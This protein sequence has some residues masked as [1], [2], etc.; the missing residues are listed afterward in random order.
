MIDDRQAS[1]VQ[2]AAH[3]ELERAARHAESMPAVTLAG[4]LQAVDK[5][6]NLALPDPVRGDLYFRASSLQINAS[7]RLGKPEGL[8]LGLSWAEEAA[9]A[10]AQSRHLQAQA[11]YNV[12]NARAALAAIGT[13]NDAGKRQVALWAERR[14]FLEARRLFSTVGHDG[15]VDGRTRAMALCN[16]AN[17]LDDAGRWVEAYDTY[18]EAIRLDPTNGNALGNAAELLRR[19]IYSGRGHSGHLAAVYNELVKAAQLR[20]TEAEAIAGKETAQRWASMKLIPTE[21]HLLHSGTGG[22]YERWVTRHRLALSEVVEGLGSD[23]PRWDSATVNRVHVR[24]GEPDPPRIFGGFA[25]IKA[26]FL[27]ARKLAY[28]GGRLLLESLYSQHPSDTGTYPELGDGSLFGQT[29][30][31]LVLAQRCTLDVLDKIAVAA[32]DHFGC[33]VPPSKVTFSNFWRDGKTGAIRQGLPAPAD[34]MSAVHALAE[35]AIDLE[36]LG[37]E[38]PGIYAVGKTLRNAGTHRIVYLTHGVPTGPTTDSYST[39][40]A[41]RLMAAVHLSLF[42]ARAAC[43]YL[44]DLIEDGEELHGSSE[45]PAIPLPGQA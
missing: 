28:D 19:R 44:I 10:W 35:L 26:E 43:L 15:L 21:G 45:A 7:D 1:R 32:N 18:D 20:L 41:D 3:R 25:S 16:L 24:P 37:G 23:D 33:G 27:V 22:E 2:Q 38:A 14:Q 11:H 30:A 5:F 9:D 42:V 17:A 4:V 12:A 40:D 39:I 8:R 13:R 34:R 29:P 6:K 31:M 36:G